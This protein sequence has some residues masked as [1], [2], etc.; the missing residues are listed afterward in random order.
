MLSMHDGK[1]LV[2]APRL[3][4]ARGFVPKAECADRLLEAV[5]TVLRG[6]TCKALFEFAKVSDRTLLEFFHPIKPVFSPE[7]LELE[8]PNCGHKSFFGQFDLTYQ[9]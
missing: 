6:E 1:P 5:D 3:I 8:C 9:A 2:D 7:L 4:G